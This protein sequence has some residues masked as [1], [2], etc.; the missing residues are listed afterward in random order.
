MSERER[1][2]V[3]VGVQLCVCECVCECAQLLTSVYMK[4]CVLDR[5][6]LDK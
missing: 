3:T 2:R 4:V 5:V 1:E 6:N